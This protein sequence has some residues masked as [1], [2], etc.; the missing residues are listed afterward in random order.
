M[1]ICIRTSVYLCVCVW[2]VPVSMH[3]RLPCLFACL[4]FRY[5]LSLSISL[6]LALF[7]L[8]IFTYIYL[9]VSPYFRWFN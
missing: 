9:C 4:A 6:Y 3:F 5:T 2:V 8:N 1:R 7:L